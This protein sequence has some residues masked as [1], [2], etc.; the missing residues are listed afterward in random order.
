MLSTVLNKN[1]V[2]MLEV[3]IYKE[4]GSPFDIVYGS[5]RYL[6]IYVSVRILFRSPESVT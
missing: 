6:K 1:K 5:T 3:F 2:N 4:K